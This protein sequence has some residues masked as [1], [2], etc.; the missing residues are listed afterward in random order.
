[1]KDKSQS[2]IIIGFKS[3]PRNHPDYY[4]LQQ[5]THVLGGM[6][7]RLFNAVRDEQGLAYYVYPNFQAEPGEGPWLVHCGVNPANVDKATNIILSELTKMRSEEV[8]EEEYKDAQSFLTGS[9][10][11]RLES[12]DQLA[13]ALLT[14]EFY[15]LGL[16]YF[17]R[18]GDIVRAIKKAD[19]LGASRKHFR[20]DTYALSIAG[21]TG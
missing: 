12:S 21:P 14:V 18:Y 5:A 11:I 17:D 9:M 6:A 3:I 20:T 2:D 13:S 15:G 4:A 10:P 19:I 1:M 8:T 7:G 16:D